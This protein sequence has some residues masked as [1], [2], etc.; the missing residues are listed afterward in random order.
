VLRL[1]VPKEEKNFSTRPS[2]SAGSPVS[3]TPQPSEFLRKT[4]VFGYS[5]RN[6]FQFCLLF[7]PL[8][9]ASF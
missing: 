7:C 3:I 5:K 6:P 4:R 9:P 8:L 1:K 2:R